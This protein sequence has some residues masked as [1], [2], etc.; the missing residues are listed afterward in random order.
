MNPGNPNCRRLRTHLVGLV[1]MLTLCGP[2]QRGYAQGADVPDPAV[3][4]KP[5]VGEYS[6]AGAVVNSLTGEPIRRAA[7][8]ISGQADRATLTDNSGHFEFDGL[9]EG[10]VS[11]GVTKP[12]FFNEQT[13]PYGRITLRAGP[14][15]SPVVLRMAPAGAIVGLVTSRDGEPLEG[16]HVRAITRWNAGG[17]QRWLDR[18][19]QAMTDEN[20]AFRIANLP[21]ATYYIALDQS[22]ETTLSQPGIPNAREQGY[23]R[24]FYPGVSELAT[25]APVELHA[26]Q[27]VETNFALTAEP[28]Y[29]VSGVVSGHED[30]P[31]GLD[32][33]RQ[34][35][36]GYD[37]SQ[38]ASTQDGKF[39]IK[40]PA[41][42]YRVRGAIRDGVLLTPPGSSVVISSDSPDLRVVSAPAPSIQ[43]AV[44]T[45]LGGGVI[46]QADTSASHG[47]PG[48]SL[49]LVSNTRSLN[50]S[51]SWWRPQ[52]GEIP[53][54]EPGVYKVEVGTMG[55]WWAKS[56]QCGNIDLLS[57]DLTVTA[58][59]QPPPIEV[60]LRD[61]AATVSGVI[62]LAEQEEPATV[63]LVQP[64]GPRNVVKATTATQGKFQFQGVAPG[65]YAVLAFDGIDK[66]EYGNPEVLNPY[67]SK[68]AHIS[69][70][71]HGTASV[72]LTLSP[73]SR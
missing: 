42:S 59:V 47:V 23:A 69:L 52:S 56:V 19:F 45:E 39:Q 51:D 13:T 17:R 10:N 20:G 1:V 60:T 5:D 58:G 38:S 49:Q 62:V 73:M 71:P 11:L 21:A 16:F 32:F 29:K 54:V 57:D 67:L 15:A 40:L 34:A 33:A 55:E 24:V 43:V 3:S 26:G 2:A 37:F 31:S 41:G 25:A 65:D 46:E 18:Q 4:S 63:L 70:Q 64:H 12:G 14:D 28:I 50:P 30:L 53:N 48:M 27:Q 35:G 7:V 61:D 22:Q 6:V 9:A 72:N 68:A 66:L 36:E 44:R 8:E